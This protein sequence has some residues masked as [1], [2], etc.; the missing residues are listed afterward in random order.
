MKD[1]AACGMRL[2]QKAF[3]AGVLAQGQSVE[4]LG[5][6]PNR[7]RR[8]DQTHLPGLTRL[9][10]RT[11]VAQLPIE[12]RQTCRGVAQRFALHDLG[13]ELQVVGWC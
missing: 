7:L 8:N 12:H 13:T 1:D 3:E 9:G 6:R 2:G 10:L 11:L 4:L 5:Q